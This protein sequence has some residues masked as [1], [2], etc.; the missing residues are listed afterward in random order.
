MKFG[1]KRRRVRRRVRRSVG[2]L[3]LAAGLV[4]IVV[5]L[6]SGIR[7]T[8]KSVAT[9]QAEQMCTKV[10]NDS[11][12]AVLA[13]SAITYDQLVHILR[14]ETDDIIAV[15][16]DIVHMN[17][18][19]AS[20]SSRVSETIGAIGERN[21]TLPAGTLTGSDFL[22]GR[23]PAITFKIKFSNA[24]TSSITSA[25]TPAGI[26]QTRHQIMLCITAKVYAIIPG[27]RTSTEVT[28]NFLLAETIIVGRVPD[29]FT[30]VDETAGSTLSGIINDY[31]Y[32]QPDLA[33]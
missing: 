26:N 17:A 31:G 14:N 33:K 10:I 22:M 11:V 28:T 6:D 27:Y 19:K 8:I 25:F 1:K 23:G 15:Q 30:N 13:D 16:A 21:V 24:M 9:Y 20:L 29:A 7:P 2:L 4:T 12:T 5:F 32:G 3:L 18:L